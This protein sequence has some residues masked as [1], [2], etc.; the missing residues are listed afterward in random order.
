MGRPTVSLVVPA[1]N[2][3]R[4]LPALLTALAHDALDDLA[5]SGLAL[6]ET[7]IVDDGSTDATAALL[8][9]AEDELQLHTVVF[10]G[11]NRG[12]GH[13]IRLGVEAAKGEYVLLTDVDL[14]APLSE[15]GRLVQAI[16]EGADI[17]VGSRVLD[18][19]QAD[20]PLLRRILRRVFN[21]I[22]RTLTGLR[23][24]DTQCGFKLM[25]TDVAR[26]LLGEQT[27]E[28]YAFDVELLMRAGKRGLRLAEVPVRYHH[29]D[30]SRVSVGR[31]G[32]QMFGAVVRLAWELRRPGADGGTS[33]ACSPGTSSPPS[34][35]A[36]SPEQA[37]TAA[38]P[39]RPA[40]PTRRG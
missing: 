1:Y 30:D 11:R 14:A 37:A 24:R 8:A 27:V 18:R 19:A 16:Q 12:K 36:R 35:A 26:T 34:T 31:A 23:I 39:P 17:A 13:A 6:V 29:D 28:G 38:P 10:A 32:V 15:A 9:A 25:R 20:S 2:E 7:V 21:D 40:E 3:E 5:A 33:S 22:V 4:R